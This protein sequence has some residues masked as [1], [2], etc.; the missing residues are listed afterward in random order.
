MSCW[1]YG[2]RGP[3]TGGQE[4]VA[5][6]HDRLVV[7]ATRPVH[8]KPAGRYL[9]P[10][11][12]L[13]SVAGVDDCRTGKGGRVRSASLRKSVTIRP[14]SSGRNSVPL[15]RGGPRLAYAVQAGAPPSSQTPSKRWCRSGLPAHEPVAGVLEAALM[16]SRAA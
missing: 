2:W 15:A 1:T 12:A 13:D 9:C 7:G 5:R 4:A 10:W 14:Q 6:A 11:V 3:C 16:S 8:G